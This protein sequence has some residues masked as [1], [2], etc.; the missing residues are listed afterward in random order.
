MEVNDFMDLNTTELF[1]DS[2]ESIDKNVEDNNSET[3][4][5]DSEDD[6]F[7]TTFS[8]DSERSG[9]GIEDCSA[10]DAEEATGDVIIGTKPTIT[11][12]EGRFS[13]STS[14][15]TAVITPAIPSGLSIIQ[16]CTK[17]QSTSDIIGLR[18]QTV[19]DNVQTI[20]RPTSVISKTIAMQDANLNSEMP[21]AN[22]S[23]TSSNETSLVSLRPQASQKLSSIVNKG[24]LNSM[25]KYTKLHT[26]LIGTV[27]ESNTISAPTKLVKIAPANVSLSTTNSVS[28]LKTSPVIFVQAP[29][30]KLGQKFT[31]LKILQKC[32]SP[33]SIVKQK[34]LNLNEMRKLGSGASL[35][36]L[37]TAAPNSTI[38]SAETNLS[39]LQSTSSL[40]VLKPPIPST[41]IAGS[42]ASTTIQLKP[43]QLYQ[44]MSSSTKPAT[45]SFV[46]APKP[47]PIA[48]GTKLIPSKILTVKP[49]TVDSTIQHHLP[50][51]LTKIPKETIVNKIATKDANTIDVVRML[52]SKQTEKS[53]EPTVT[54]GQKQMANKPASEF[55][56]LTNFLS[57]NDKPKSL[58]S[59]SSKHGEHLTTL[60]T[61]NGKMMG[62]LDETRAES[63]TISNGKLSNPHGSIKV[64]KSVSEIDAETVD[65]AKSPNVGA[66][67]GNCID[68][69]LEQLNTSPRLLGRSKSLT[70]EK[71]QS[72]VRRRYPSSGNTIPTRVENENDASNEVWQSRDKT[73]KPDSI[74]EIE[75]LTEEKVIEETLGTERIK[76]VGD[77][78]EC[79]EKIDDSDKSKSVSPDVLLGNVRQ[80]PTTT[81]TTTIAVSAA[82]PLPSSVSSSSHVDQKID[83]PLT[84]IKWRNG[85]GFLRYSNLT[86]SKNEFN[87][88]EVLE[89]KESN[90]CQ[91]NV[92]MP[93]LKA[94]ESST[95]QIIDLVDRRADVGDKSGTIGRKKIESKLRFKR[96][97]MN[98]LQNVFVWELYL[99][100]T[101]TQ[102]AP[103]SLFINPFPSS[104]NPFEVGMKMEAIDP[105]HCSLFCVCTVVEKLG[106]RIR[107]SFDGYGDKFSFWRNAD[108]M[109]IFPAG[110]CA[111][112]GRTL[113]PP[114]RYASESFDWHRYLLKTNAK[115][116]PRSNFTHLNSMTT[117]NPFKCGM[118]FEA[119]HLKLGRG[120]VGVATVGD[121][122]DNRILVQFDGFDSTHDY[123]AD[124]TS[125]NIHPY[126]W[127][128]SNNHRLIVAKEYERNFSWHHY[129]AASMSQPVPREYF[130]RRPPIGFREGM[131]LEIVD[132]K[133]P[134]LI[135]P[136]TVI[137]VADYHIQVL[138]DGW[139]ATY[140]YWIE[141]DHP[142]IH[143]I[144][145]CLKTEHPL[146]PPL[147]FN[148]VD[149]FR[150]SQCG[151]LGCRELGNAKHFGVGFHYTIFECPYESRNWLMADIKPDRLFEAKTQK[152]RKRRA[153]PITSGTESYQRIK[154]DLPSSEENS[155]LNAPS[156][157]WNV[158][159][160]RIK[161]EEIEIGETK[162]QTSVPVV[163]PEHSDNKI[164]KHIQVTEPILRDYGPAL[165][166]I[167]KLWTQ[168]SKAVNIRHIAKN[169]MCWTV[170][171]V[172]DYVS[173]LPNC[174]KLGK[175]FREHEIDG[176][177]FLKLCQNDLVDV[178]EI[179]MGPAVK[180]YNQIVALRSEVC[181]NY[182]ESD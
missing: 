124:I 62:K 102:A 99:R 7:A 25:A 9:N 55:Q 149:E 4:I 81:T 138:F 14:V 163:K 123:W 65:G 142:D 112:N 143:P 151:V 162:L 105:E 83:D 63:I 37:N 133:V 146:E 148:E 111:K 33:G 49:G 161:N 51:G 6:N 61:S 47:A 16:K 10:A 79:D 40:I 128:K 23:T 43:Q 159:P 114:L 87:L 39:Y 57:S 155:L 12:E 118:K 95:E 2:D 108:S 46:T 145:W 54:I 154:L 82:N 115:F 22:V 122:L 126:N 181:E 116:A 86:F 179:R 77:S 84:Y 34:I 20:I 24:Q 60:E 42:Q 36:L 41:S 121:V 167:H 169:P 50:A 94:N 29:A 74:E 68:K 90:K 158:Q 76:T 17:T 18:K 11:I 66:N 173:R 58:L 89:V 141:D 130:C 180:V 140:S 104:P 72:K 178:L 31:S 125:P 85:V 152:V 113:Q 165:M 75:E 8:S 71:H 153:K 35:K 98:L 48:I 78:L 160:T 175:L 96:A 168:N 67:D 177:S 174:T 69:K 45:I 166:H 56:S 127:H 137:R 28:E 170:E 101:D 139:P 109:E 44:T 13:N 164:P 80:I 91:K 100:L 30:P 129:L 64:L 26:A 176:D 117:R 88:L 53:V 106:Y 59:S 93:S 92:K 70:I 182:M 150:S 156:V 21:S 32:P 132:K 110:W 73:A 107:L 1:V 120:K 19:T 27:T 134:T 147:G 97:G 52:K 3:L 144:N 136:C 157:E 15:P 135:R 119:D 131:K 172:A 103:D 38:S 171:E 5:L